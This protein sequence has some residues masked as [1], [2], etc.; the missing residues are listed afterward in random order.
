MDFI[1]EFV[2]EFLFE[3]LFEGTSEVLSNKKL[4]KWLRVLLGILLLL[5]FLAVIVLVIYAGYICLE[6]TVLGGIVIMAIGVILLIG[7]S[8]KFFKH[9][10]A[11]KSG[12]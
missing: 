6:K 5:V 10:D 11:Y 3:L 4:P 12:K 7:G 1:I 2:L 8:V 9:W